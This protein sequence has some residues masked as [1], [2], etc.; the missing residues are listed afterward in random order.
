MF[1]LAP[2]VQ[3][4]LAAFAPLFSSPVWPHAQTLLIG[5][6]LCPGK[7]TVTSALRVMGLKD[8]KC[9]TN[10]HRVL[11]RAKWSLLDGSKVLLGLLVALIPANWPVI[12]TMDETIERRKGDKIKAKGCY[13]DAVRS[14]KSKVVH[15]FGLKWIAMML[16]VPLP[17]AK[18]T[19]ALPFLTVLAPSKSANEANNKKHKTTVDWTR[20]MI[21]LVRRW[22]P[23]RAIV[24]VGDGAYAAVSLALCCAGFPVPV[25]LVSRLRLDAALYDFPP[26]EQPG[27]RGPKPKKGKKQASLLERIKDTKLKWKTIEVIWYDGIKRSL[28]ILSGVSM[29]YTPGFDPI[30]IKWV[31]VRD[32][33]GKLRT[34]AFF[35]TNLNIAAIQIIRWF[36]FRWN[37]E[38]TFEELR[39]HLGFETQRQ[40]SKLAIART[41][42]V[43]FGL[44]SIIV[45]FVIKI[46][47]DSPL[48]VLS[49]AW[50]KKPEATFSDV[51]AAARRHIW[52]INYFVNL[53]KKPNISYLF[54]D[55]IQHLLEQLCYAA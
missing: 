34:E 19:W 24:L 37:I 39:A 9:F 50:Y 14:S 48:A 18:R 5:A 29:W 32:P 17:W 35:S 25:T 30:A 53:S 28:E 43:L 51:I 2:E 45:L 1:N 46:T 52:T 10:F 21:M 15:C 31:V 8:E 42:P 49:C 23:T 22:I 54:D 47:K 4:I 11:N 40:W 44:F 16:I 41:T 13:R 26:E 38:V 20:Q 12:I 27:K 33:K 36:I 7:R 55:P 6:I 3:S